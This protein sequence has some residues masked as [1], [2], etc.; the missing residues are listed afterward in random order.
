MGSVE[1][2][3][4]G[5]AEERGAPEVE[6]AAVGG[7]EPV[8]LAVRRR[9]DVHDRRGRAGR[10]R[11]AERGVAE[12]E[13]GAPVRCQPV[14][15]TRGGAGHAG[16][17][18]AGGRPEGLGVAGRHDGAGTRAVGPG[19]TGRTGD[20]QGAGGRRTGDHH[21][22]GDGA[23]TGGGAGEPAAA[24]TRGGMDGVLHAEVLPFRA[25]LQAWRGRARGEGR[26]A[27]GASET[28]DR[29]GPAS[30][31]GRHILRAGARASTGCDCLLS[32]EPPYP[33]RSCNTNKPDGPVPTQRRAASP[34]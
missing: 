29:R 7:D 34:P 28:R 9:R 23:P 21:G 3:V 4:A 12:G 2:T 16:D 19:P 20:L 17:G 14:A 27:A 32:F 5:R 1:R 6:D 24:E 18:V 26:A 31:G 11:T 10:Q 15:V 30:R 22:Q 25:T 33:R 13:D 8:T